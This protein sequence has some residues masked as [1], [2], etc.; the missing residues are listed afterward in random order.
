M[1]A[2]VPRKPSPPA[3]PS[4]NQVDWAGL[5]PRSK[6]TLRVCWQ[7]LLLGW[8]PTEIAQSIGLPPYAVS[9]ALD[10]LREDC[11]P[12]GLAAAACA[13]ALL[14]GDAVLVAIKAAVVPHRGLVEP[15]AALE[16]RHTAGATARVVTR[17][18]PAHSMRIPRV[19][20]RAVIPD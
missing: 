16:R 7:P 11:R 6:A 5:S 10:Q 3:P 9:D 15:R 12:S 13:L 2:P 19:H 1:S 18:Q 17:V 8:T 20:A 4:A 14:A